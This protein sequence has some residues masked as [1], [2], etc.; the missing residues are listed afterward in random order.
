MKKLFSKT[1]AFVAAAIL[2]LGTVAVAQTLYYGWNPSTGFET[3]H[4]FPLAGGTVPTLGTATA[5][6]TTATVQASAVGGSSVVQF[7]AGA[8]SCTLVLTLPTVVT[9]SS[10]VSPV[11]PNGIYC[12]AADETTSAD[13]MKQTAHTTNS[14]TL[15]GT[16]VVGDKIIVEINAY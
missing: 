2:G 14:C 10:T 3:F 16:V 13:S 7:T 11:A 12:V 6:G 1:A 4:G 9:A 8:T 15:T 5:C